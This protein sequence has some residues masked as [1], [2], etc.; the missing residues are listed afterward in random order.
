MGLFLAYNVLLF[1]GI[2]LLLP[3]LFFDTSTPIH[4]RV[5]DLS[6]GEGLGI[7]STKFFRIYRSLWRQHSY[8]L[9]CP[10]EPLLQGQ[11]IVVTGAN[12]GIGFET[13]K[14]LAQRKARVIMA[15]RSKNKCIE[16]SKRIKGEFPGSKLETVVLNL[17][18]LGSVE[19]AVRQIH[20]LAKEV[21][22]V[23]ANAGVLPTDVYTESAQGFEIAFAVNNLGH[24]LLLDRMTSKGMLKKRKSRVVFVTGDIYVLADDCTSAFKYN[25]TFGGIKAYA[26]SKLGNLWQVEHMAKDFPW[27]HVYAV[28]PGVIDTNLATAGVKS[29]EGLS[30]LLKL[31]TSVRKW[32]LLDAEMGAQTTLWVA[33]RD[34]SALQNGAYYHNTMGR[35][36][37]DRKD[38]VLN[39][40]K[41]RRFWKEMQ[42]VVAEWTKD[43]KQ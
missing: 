36:V 34:V 9:R 21:D 33:T 20:A 35:M 22:V 15:C 43:N 23:V 1:L 42:D 5:T 28:H 24:Q 8:T 31:Y 4:N 29:E 41:S 40:T 6:D 38:N 18:D 25:S 14:G 26:R 32:F 7:K 13:A 27:L 30:F 11:T 2:A 16:A 3:A 17:A 12:G 10:S 39:G 19:S 37:L